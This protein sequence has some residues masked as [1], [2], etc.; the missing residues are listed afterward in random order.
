VSANSGLRA[1]LQRLGEELGWNVY[2]PQFQY[3]TDN[4]GMIAMVAHFKAEKVN[5]VENIKDICAMQ[6]TLI[7][8]L[9][10]KLKKQL[11]NT[12]LKIFCWWGV[13]QF[14]LACRIATTRRGVG[15]ECIY[16]SVF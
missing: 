13:G 2:I 15:L 14:R 6:H 9:L 16:S 4:A 8:I 12:K 5:F 7:K 1:E 11:S 10:Q 3:C